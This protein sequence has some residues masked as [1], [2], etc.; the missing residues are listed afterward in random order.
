MAHLTPADE[1]LDTI[2]VNPAR[3]MGLAWDGRIAI[4][5]PADLVLLAATDEHELLDG[6]GRARTVIRAGETIAS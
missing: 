6:K 1:W 2:T 3:A 5:C 4:G